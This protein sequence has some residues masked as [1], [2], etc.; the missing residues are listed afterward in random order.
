MPRARPKSPPIY[1][2]MVTLREVEPPV[3]RRLVLPGD[4]TLG[5]LHWAIQTAMGWG[6]GHLHAFRTPDEEHVYS[7]DTAEIEGAKDEERVSLRKVAP[8]VG[9]QLVYEYDFGDGWEH[10]VR[11]EAIDYPERPAPTIVCIEG[12]RSC[13]PD[14]VGGAS[15]YEDFLAALADP[16]HREHE[17]LLEWCGGGFD[18]DAFSIEA[19]NARL[20]RPWTR[21]GFPDDPSG[22]L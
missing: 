20:S 4:V 1:R 15:G 17:N 14:D 11:V 7:D 22:I 16:D 21:L 5:A 6:G 3:W 18:P 2:V 13:P 8:A 19:V 9:S 10:D 12:A